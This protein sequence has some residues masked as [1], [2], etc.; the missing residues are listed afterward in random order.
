[1]T[2]LVL[3]MSS[4]SWWIH[5]TERAV[6]PNLTHNHLYIV[7]HHFF[8]VCGY[9]YS[10]WLLASNRLHALPHSSRLRQDQ[11]QQREANIIME[12]E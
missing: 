1:M 2:A 12:F 6:L 7:L 10:S 4:S 11:V 3:R 8:P 9:S 5:T